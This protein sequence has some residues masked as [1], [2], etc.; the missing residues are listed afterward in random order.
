MTLP[1]GCSHR[2]YALNPYNSN[3][4]KRDGIQFGAMT[5]YG[6]AMGV[7]WMKG[8]EIGEAIPPAYSEYL[9]AELLATLTESAAHG[10]E[11]SYRDCY[12]GVGVRHTEKGEMLMSKISVGSK[13][14]MQG[15]CECSYEPVKGKDI[16]Y[17][18][19]DCYHK[20][21]AV[22]HVFRDNSSVWVRNRYNFARRIL[23]KDLL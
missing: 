4:R 10:W 5:H 3:A 7:D 18:S 14:R 11:A 8:K 16:W 15:D 21:N 22:R 19:R 20:P 13:V 9:G 2:E 12:G 1:R 6:K 17:D 23:N